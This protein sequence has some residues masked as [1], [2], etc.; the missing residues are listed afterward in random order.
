[1]PGLVES[2]VWETFLHAR[3]REAGY[4]LFSASNV[5]LDHCKSFGYWEFLSQRFYLA[6]SFAGM[7]VRNAPL[8]R[9]LLYGAA[10]PALLVI[11]PTRVATKVWKKNKHRKELAKSFPILMTFMGSWTAGE[12]VG[13]LF[14]E[15]DAS[16]K[17][18]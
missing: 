13:Y 6:R 14:G 5:L 8:T 4:R 17:V 3:L 18:E 10:S 11:L 9:K 2:A 7:R 15:G 16:S 1:M 12:F